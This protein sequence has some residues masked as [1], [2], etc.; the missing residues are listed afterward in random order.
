MSRVAYLSYSASLPLHALVESGSD[1]NFIDSN[2]VSQAGIPTEILSSPTDALSL[3]S[4][5]LTH[6][7]HR[8]IPL[9]LIVS[10]N[11]RETI[12]FFVI[13]SPHSPLVLGLPWLRLHNPH[14][15]WVTSSIVNWST[16]C[17]SNCL[18]SAVPPANTPSPVPLETIDLSSVP[19]DYHDLRD[20]FS[21][22]RALCLTPH[23]P[24]D[25]PIN[26]LPGAPLPTSRLYSLSQPE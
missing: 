21:K 24:Y 6:I 4:N 12:Q 5:L 8:T 16:F 14:I 19:S 7:T 23:R 11:H 13:S 10:G 18:H 9:S 22:D 1:D 26:L 3:D 17:H 15:N 2:L 20:V 25:C